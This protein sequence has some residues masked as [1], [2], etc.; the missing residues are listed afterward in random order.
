MT[1]IRLAQSFRFLLHVQMKEEM[2]IFKNENR[3]QNTVAL[4]ILQY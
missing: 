4:Q 3:H 2:I 1:M